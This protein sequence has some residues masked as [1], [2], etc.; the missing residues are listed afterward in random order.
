M[1]QS[2][3]V[4][5]FVDDT[6]ALLEEF[7]SV[8]KWQGYDV[9]TAGRFNEAIEQIDQAPQI[10]LAL[11]DLQLPL[12]G[13][14]KL[15]ALLRG[16]GAELGFFVAEHL[17]RKFPTTPILFW[18]GSADQSSRAKA[19][20]FADALCL[21]K[22]TLPNLVLDLVRQIMENPNR[23]PPRKAFIVHGHADALLVELRDWLAS[24]LQ[25]DDPVVLRDMPTSGL[26]VIDKL[27]SYALSAEL[28]FVLLTPDDLVLASRQD[29]E[30]RR[31]R[32]NV[33]F[34]MGYFFG[35]LGRRTGN[36][37]LLSS[38]RVE[39][40]SDIHGMITIDVTDGIAAAG[41]E[42][43]REIDRRG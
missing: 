31:A 3:P 1:M 42:I 22:N 29:L 30:S 8:L 39:L 4:V 14:D 43:R 33:I 28:V 34:E 26:T 9:L 21:P 13:S 18:S 36:I 15:P 38:G 24:E 27:E 12:E 16:N 35:R 2:R 25:I 5:L 20:R 37:V 40:P 7:T 6:L 11:L 17:R 41:K 32:Q 10:D 23:R 19:V